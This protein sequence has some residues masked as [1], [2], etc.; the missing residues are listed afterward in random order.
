MKT[1]LA[2]CASAIALA[3]AAPAAADGI[4]TWATGCLTSR[5]T[6]DRL[7]LTHSTPK[8]PCGSGETQ[9]SLKLEVAGVAFGRRR[10][11]TALNDGEEA[12]LVPPGDSKFAPYVIL[13]KTDEGGGGCSVYLTSDGTA[14]LQVMGDDV[15]DFDIA[16]IAG[17]PDNVELIVRDLAYIAL[18]HS[19]IP[20]SAL[21]IDNVVVSHSNDE[22]CAA[23]VTVRKAASAMD[24]FAQ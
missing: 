9:V 16:R 11:T 3:V 14:T 10:A 13:L 5:N 2:L 1:I 7:N 22:G 12:F 21:L 15:S 17:V 24:F 20:G 8:K 23:A 4:E 18:P 6:I 19:P